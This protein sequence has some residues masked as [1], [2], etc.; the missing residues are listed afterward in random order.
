MRP[1]PLSRG[2]SEMERWFVYEL[3]SFNEA[4]AVKPRKPGEVCPIARPY[5]IGFNE[6]AAVKPRKP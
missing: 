6:A 1:R 4:A 3:E 5:F 2:N